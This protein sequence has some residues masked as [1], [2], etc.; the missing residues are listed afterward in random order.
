MKFLREFS[1][2][3]GLLHK[4]PKGI[5]F[6]S[7]GEGSLGAGI[8]RPNADGSGNGRCYLAHGDGLGDAAGWRSCTVENDGERN[9]CCA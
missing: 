6:D 4:I 7:L 2:N 1:L 9:K 8:W 5:F 3:D